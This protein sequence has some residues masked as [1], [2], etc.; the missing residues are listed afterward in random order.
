LDKEKCKVS[1]WM[2]NDFDSAEC[3]KCNKNFEYVGEW[4]GNKWQVGSMSD[5]FHWLDRKWDKK[6]KWVS[7]VDSWRL[8]HVM[9]ELVERLAEETEAQFVQCMYTGLMESVKKIACVCGEVSSKRSEREDGRARE[10][11]CVRGYRLRYRMVCPA[12]LS[13]CLFYFILISHY[14]S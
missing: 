9:R 2:F 14:L 5:S 1:D 10:G 8:E 3:A 6:N 12:G 11:G 13:S 4:H 7:E